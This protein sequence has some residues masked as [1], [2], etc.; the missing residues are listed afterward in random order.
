VYEAVFWYRIQQ[1]GW[2]GSFFLR[3]DGVDPGDAFL[4]R[5]RRA[6]A[7]VKKYSAAY[8]DNSFPAVRD[9]STGAAGYELYV[10]SMA[11]ISPTKAEV[12]GGMY[13]SAIC[14]DDGI[15]YLSKEKNGRW[16]VTRYKM[17]NVS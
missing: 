11:W 4:A 7:P 2:T 13:C 1:R 14:A 15:Y 9:K 8:I 6:K 5:F 12:L 16:V 17:K 10:T 3:I